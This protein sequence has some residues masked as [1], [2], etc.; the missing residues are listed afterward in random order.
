MFIH[1]LDVSVKGLTEFF[2]H[3]SS[4]RRQVTWAASDFLHRSVMKRGT[5]F[6]FHFARTNSPPNKKPVL[7]SE[8]H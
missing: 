7:D 2:P 8:S 3:V 1:Y 6:M 5:F 4:L